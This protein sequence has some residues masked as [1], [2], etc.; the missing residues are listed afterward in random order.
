MVG[1]LHSGQSWAT[2][3]P[4]PQSTHAQLPR[5]IDTHEVDRSREVLGETSDVQSEVGTQEKEAGVPDS[6]KE[7]S[8]AGE[9]VDGQG[10]G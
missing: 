8:C 10:R 9:R 3:P 5:R 7:P 1:A 4:A 2:V 6:E